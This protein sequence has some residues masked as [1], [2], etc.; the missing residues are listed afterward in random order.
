MT[1]NLVGI[2]VVIEH[3]E[4]LEMRIVVLEACE[5]TSRKDITDLKD[6]L[7]TT[8]KKV[9]T[10]EARIY[11]YYQ[12]EVQSCEGLKDSAIMIAPHSDGTISAVRLINIGDGQNKKR[13]EKG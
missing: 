1:T 5:L 13:K 7:N 6:K 11:D 8:Q 4:K 10:L 12:I 3:L 2:S 9:T